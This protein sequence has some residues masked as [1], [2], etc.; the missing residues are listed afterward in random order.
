MRT[1]SLPRALGLAALVQTACSVHGGTEDRAGGQADGGSA[2]ADAGAGDPGGPG[3]CGD[4]VCSPDETDESCPP[5]CGCRAAA[6]GQEVA[7]YGCQCDGQ[8]ADRGD[9]CADVDICNNAGVGRVI[10]IYLKATDAPAGQV[11]SVSATYQQMFDWVQRW[12]MLEM[13]D[14]GYK[15]FRLEPVRVLPS[16]HTRAQWDT[17]S[18]T[19]YPGQ[20]NCDGTGGCSMWY[21]ASTLLPQLLPAA[22]LPPIGSA[23]VLYYVVNGGGTNGSC[24]GG[25]LAASEEEVVTAIQMSC[26]TGHYASGGTDCS[27]IG[28]I[29]HEQGHAFG[30]PHAMDRPE[31]CT[32]GPSVM[33]VWWDYDR[34][35]S[36]CDEDRADLEA[37]GYFH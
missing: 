26:P 16:P 25:G 15:T 3:V 29:A 31:G 4:A 5:D 36:L 18:T 24:G 32:G 21:A 8:C 6:C 19:C 9:C 35:A 10:P 20:T 27:M 37:S 12:Y 17:Y 14:Q 28:V 22:G 34:G 11:D 2:R 7:P 23:G 30:L 13:A 1:G 33:D